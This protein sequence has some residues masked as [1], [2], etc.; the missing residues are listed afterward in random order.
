METLSMWIEVGSLSLLLECSH[1]LLP[2][3]M[4]F[5]MC[6]RLFLCVVSR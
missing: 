3:C 1:D 2:D 6:S 4:I 5:S